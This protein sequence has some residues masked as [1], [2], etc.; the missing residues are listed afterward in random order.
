MNGKTTVT[1][2]G[3]SVSSDSSDNRAGNN[4]RWLAKYSLLKNPSKVYRQ[5][6]KQRTLCDVLS[7]EDNGSETIAM[8][9][10]N[11]TDAHSESI[12][13]PPFVYKNDLNGH[14]EYNKV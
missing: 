1:M 9:V 13:S 3:R 10:M 2:L 4:K 6:S 12:N 5:R 7:I 11:K 14:S 8:T